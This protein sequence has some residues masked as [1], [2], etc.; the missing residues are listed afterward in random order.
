MLRRHF[1]MSGFAFALK[2]EPLSKADALIRAAVDSGEIAAASLHV[3]QGSSVYKRAYGLARDENAAFLLASITKPMTATAVMIL[4]D[5]GKLR[6]QDPV[7]RYIQ[8]FQGEG[9]DAVTIRHLLTHTSGLPDMLPENEALRKRSAPL[10]EFVAATCKTPLLFK[11]GTKVQYQSMGI[12]L[13]G[14]IVERITGTALPRFL[15]KEVFEPL[16]MSRTSL[17]LG[18]R[19]LSEF[20]PSQVPQASAW[21]WN[22]RYWRDLGSPWG[23]ALASAG[24]VARFLSLPMLRDG[25]ILKPE[26]AAAMIQNQTQGIGAAWGL[27]WSLEPGSFGKSCSPATFGH[28]GSTGTLAWCDPGSG[29]KCVLLTSKPDAKIRKPVSD[30]VAEAAAK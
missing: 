23:G 11:P 13:A 25:K 18:G 24:D 26:T 2:E 30:L 14:E 1:L 5:R 3:E 20:V 29:T 7:S 27:G 21:D 12:L 10:K 28:S 19:S 4:S 17:G 8:E 6:I 9:R 22:S 15:D 16:K